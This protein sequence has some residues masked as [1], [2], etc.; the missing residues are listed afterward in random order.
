MDNLIWKRQTQ[1]Y[2]QHSNQRQ[3]DQKINLQIDHSKVQPTISK[4]FES[5][6]ETLSEYECFFQRKMW[7]F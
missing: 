6:K 1:V 2:F 3:K 4:C 7:T 5:E